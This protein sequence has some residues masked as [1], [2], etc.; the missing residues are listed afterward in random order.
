MRLRILGSGAGGGVPQWNCACPN[1]VEARTGSGRVRPR[2][3][4][5][6]AV[7]GGDG[8]AWFLVNAS[9]DVHRQIEASPEL[10]PRSGRGSPIRGILL[11]NGD[12]DHCLG[13]LSLRESTP[14]VVY[15]T[16][17]VR[18]GLM[19]GN[20]LLRTLQRF[21]GHLTWRRLALDQPIELDGADGA[22]SGISV[23]PFAI[24]GKV[25]KHLEGLAAPSAEDNI[26]LRIREASTGATVVHATSV[27]AWGDHAARF[28]D[29]DVC[30]LD[31]TF[32]SSDELI[33][34]GLGKAR[35]EDMAHMPIGGPD[36]SL[37][38]AGEISARRKVY[39]HLNNSN[40]ILLDGSAERREVEAA[41]FEVAHD[42]L[43]M[44]LP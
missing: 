7:S 16:D 28:G 10:H 3:Q 9:P 21:P 39:T 33:A 37:T 43:E 27:G 40:P 14:L 31:G 30:L 18:A 1:C 15:A 23:I 17:A 6:I 42:G 34:L 2:T 20:T 24:P 44:A 22:R 13:L 19:E 41:G 36:G 29:A 8:D 32:W 4:E 11:T 5:S 38:R 26:G 25:A 12:L 35:A